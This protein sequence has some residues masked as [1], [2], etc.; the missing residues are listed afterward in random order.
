MKQ[1]LYFPLLALLFGCSGRT[2]TEVNLDLLSFLQ[3]SGQPTAFNLSIAP[4]DLF[5]PNNPPQYPPGS[6]V[7]VG[8][9][10]NGALE[11]GKLDLEVILKG[12]VGSTPNTIT[13]EARLAGGNDSG[14]M[15]D[16]LGSDIQLVSKSETIA[17][18]QSKTVAI[19][20]NL[21]QDNAAALALMNSGAFKFALRAGATGGTSA[22]LEVS[23]LSIAVSGKVFKLIPKQ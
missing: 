12:T 6:G 15:Y 19:A 3:V 17:A 8:V 23:K 20:L 13:I 22:T 2:T 5:I 11:G 9:D 21:P 10:L 16:N 18:G 7:E 4:Q 14:T 1:L